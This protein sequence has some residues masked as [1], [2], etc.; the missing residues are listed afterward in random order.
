MAITVILV[1]ILIFSILRL[2]GEDPIDL[3]LGPRA[4]AEAEA[5]LRAEYGLDQPLYLQYFIW[6]GNMFQGNFGISI[7][8][9]TDVL[10]LIVERIPYTL[11]ITFFGMIFSVIVGIPSGVISAL[12]QYS[13]TDYGVTIFSFIGLSMPRFW[14]GLLFIMFIATRVEFIPVSG[15]RGWASIILPG[16]TLG[17]PQIARVSRLMRTEMLEI[18]REEFITAARVKG[19]KE[20]TVIITHALRNAIIPVVVIQ[21]LYLP[22]LIGGSVVV[23][24]VFAWP[25]MGRLLF[26]AIVDLDFPVV[27]GIVFI[28]AILTVISN[29]IGDLISYYLDPR[30][31]KGGG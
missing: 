4:T 13:K 18:K 31:K 25:G 3:M 1:S 8:R 26:Q 5:R 23:E 9:R 20:K 21:F 2:T 29:F 11:A 17:L 12:K 14:L 30:I 15:Y 19:L 24:E 6:L 16:L 22:W 10:S 27:Q 7:V 28:I